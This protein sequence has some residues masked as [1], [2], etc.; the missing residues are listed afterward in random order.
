MSEAAHE[1]RA[2]IHPCPVC[3]LDELE[4]YPHRH[5]R[6][7]PAWDPMPLRPERL[8]CGPLDVD[9]YWTGPDWRP[10]CCMLHVMA[11]EYRAELP[12]QLHPIHATST[13]GVLP[14]PLEPRNFDGPLLDAPDIGLGF[15]WA[16][17]AHRRLGG[18]RFDEG[19]TYLERGDYSAFPWAYAIETRLLG[20]CRR[21]HVTRPD[22]WWEHRA[23]PI[24]SPIMRLILARGFPPESL[25]Q[26]RVVPST[27]IR[28]QLD[29]VVPGIWARVSEAVNETAL[30]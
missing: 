4:G 27:R 16:A 3:R 29:D 25:V 14:I 20:Y 1:L 12:E 24:C 5:H 30:R 26:R 2:D 22:L 9:R 6:D 15:P 8:Y 19:V 11:A 28:P 10:S 21:R 18:L 23:S 13:T 7:A 17:R